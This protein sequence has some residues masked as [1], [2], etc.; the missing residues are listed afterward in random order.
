MSEQSTEIRSAGNNA[1][2]RQSSWRSLVS[3]LSNVAILFFLSASAFLVPLKCHA[4]TVTYAS[5]ISDVQNGLRL[6]LIANAELAGILIGQVQSADKEHLAG[7]NKVASATL[8]LCLLTIRASQ[9]LGLITGNE[10]QL[11]INDVQ[12]LKNQLTTTVLSLSITPSG[13]ITLSTGATQQLHA[14]A[15]YSNGAAMDVTTAATWS[16]SNASVASVSAGLVKATGTGTTAIS[17]ALAGQTASVGLTVTPT[18]KAILVA[19]PAPSIALG[20]TQQFTATANYSDG[21]SKD[22]SNT[23][24]W[25]SSTTSVATVSATG[26]AKALAV[27]ST[28]ITATMLGISG[29]AI[30]TVPKALASITVTPSSPIVSIGASNQ[31]VATGK[32]NDG[33]SQDLT[34]LATWSSSNTSVSTV[35][36]T[37][38]DIAFDT[39]TAQVSATLNGV[40]GSTTV[41]VSATS[42][43]FQLFSNLTDPHILEAS[44]FD[45]YTIDY[46]G[47]KDTT[48]LATGVTSIRITFPN[49]K[50]ST[51]T[52][53][54]T[55]RPTEIV[56]TSGGALT[57]SWQSSTQGTVS[58][59]S[60][61]GSYSTGPLTLTLPATSTSSS[62]VTAK[63]RTLQKH[64]MSQDEPAVNNTCNIVVTRCGGR[65]VQN[66]SVYASI[67]GLLRISGSPGALQPSPPGDY[68]FTIPV[69]NPGIV[70]T[71]AKLCSAVASSTEFVCKSAEVL[72]VALPV[73]S[74]L[75]AATGVGIPEAGALLIVSDEIEASSLL[76]CAALDGPP[77]DAATGAPGNLD[78]L[79]ESAV[80]PLVDNAVSSEIIISP[81]AIL[82]GHG[83]L[84]GVPQ[85]A[86]GTGPFMDFP[87]IDFT[88]TGDCGIKSVSITPP[89]PSI[90]VG[91]TLTLVAM[92]LDGE[93]ATVPN[94][95]FTWSSNDPSVT[96]DPNTGV[97]TGVS[98]GTATIT[99]TETTSQKQGSTTVTVTTSSGG[100]RFI[101]VAVQDGQTLSVQV[102]G[103]TI[104]SYVSTNP[105]GTFAVFQLCQIPDSTSLTVGLTSAVSAAYEVGLGNFTVNDYEDLYTAPGETYTATLETDTCI[106]TSSCETLQQF[107]APLFGSSI[108]VALANPSCVTIPGVNSQR[109]PAASR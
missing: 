60:P 106:A 45:G 41:T 18:L 89:T 77:N 15:R 81:V 2:P 103:V 10:P 93:G 80:I 40:V 28:S 105:T 26:L 55:G 44:T 43:Q 98:A 17:A 76:V 47:T 65:P 84:P 57:F 85:T 4:E 62:A 102:N 78:T 3:S 64:L 56:G 42:P 91:Q 92:A 53:D 79:C 1:D 97:I 25:T 61:D 71:A 8:D 12:S 51:F 38:F 73:I 11:L 75:L 6:K 74:A 95:I 16:S 67:T 83:A 90:T 96:I 22:V 14:T 107:E 66:A 72:A 5:T 39:G 23:V 48:G 82:P 35:S 63:L 87:P 99:A 27:G 86:P 31:L 50:S 94:S 46:F 54:S 101:G 36:S 24:A 29:S 52:L 9:G 7:N 13:P 104:G 58:A 109:S 108:T 100:D 30:L 21:S 37:G 59:I 19:P 34:S 33:S 88:D 49:G 69:P 32:Y 20:A 68:L 70:P